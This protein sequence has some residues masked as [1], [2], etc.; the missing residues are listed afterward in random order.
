MDLLYNTNTEPRTSN[1]EQV[2][3]ANLLREGGVVEG[4]ALVSMNYGVLQ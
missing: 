3:S 2:A 4:I 1:S